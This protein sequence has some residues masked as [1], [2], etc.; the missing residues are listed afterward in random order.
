M[1]SAAAVGFHCEDAK[2]NL[3]TCFMLNSSDLLQNKLLVKPLVA[4]CTYMCML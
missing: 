4:M 3:Q 1:D 2:K